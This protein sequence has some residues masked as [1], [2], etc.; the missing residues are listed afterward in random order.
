MKH[1]LAA[2]RT[3]FTSEY[4]IWVPLIGGVSIVLLYLSLHNTEI[5]LLQLHSIDEY[6]FHGSVLY[7][8]HSLIRLHL[9]GMFGYGFYQYG[10]IYFFLNLLA[11]LPGL[12]FHQTW[13][14]IVVPRLVTG[15]FAV[16]SLLV[17]YR[18]ARLYLEKIP[19]VLFAT[20]FITMPAFWYNATWFHPDWVMTFFLLATAF[21]LARDYGH[22][23]RHFYAGII[24]YGLAVAFK[25]QAITFF[26]LIGLY[27]FYDLGTLRIPTQLRAKLKT[28]LVSLASI[29]S[30]FLIANPYILHPMGW[31]A[32]STSFV[33]NMLSNAT[34]HGN[35]GVVSVSE[36]ISEAI[37]S[38]YCNILFVFLLL[39]ATTWLVTRY[40]TDRERSIFIMLAA[41]FLVNIAYLL[42]FV[43]KA[44]QVY[45]LPVI[46]TGLLVTLAFIRHIPPK[47]LTVYLL[48]ALLIQIVSFNTT[49]ITTLTMSRDKAA[50]PDFITYSPQE[51]LVL[52]NFIHHTLAGRVPPTAI[53]LISAYTPFQFEAVGLP[54]ENVNTIYGALDRSAFDAD[55]YLAGQ[56]AYWGSLKTDAE[57]MKTFKPAD[58]IILRKD[59][60]YIDTTRITGIVDQKSY[61]SAHDL[62]LGLYH[63]A[64]PY[65]LLGENPYVVIFAAIHN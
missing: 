33:Q 32:F 7:M 12:V 40:R 64:Y 18:F 9:A 27:I 20:F 45:Y 4:K 24:C 34:N 58:F 60:P 8:Y 25:Y 30:I 39:V 15:F 50:A 46:T 3:L 42:F 57:L 65:T 63:G 56:R 52:Q 49:Y 11:C 16:A 55:A 47:R 14:T 48:C 13:L 6:V 5:G 26:P 35:S 21:C 62:I 36:K 22:F 31:R 53:V 44:W 54:F 37:T 23:G 61:Y 38:Y 19:A 41:N 2:F 17:I 29:G 43:N 10:F 28:F 1:Y 51:Q 59:A